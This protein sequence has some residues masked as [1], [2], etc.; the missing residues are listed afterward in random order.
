MGGE[1][2]G[3]CSGQCDKTWNLNATVSRDKMD[4]V[5]GG[6]CVGEHWLIEQENE[7]G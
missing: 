4:V 3:C 2:R 5:K 7:E 6:K 1:G